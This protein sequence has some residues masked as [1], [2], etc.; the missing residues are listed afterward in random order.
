MAPCSGRPSKNRC[1]LLSARKQYFCVT[2][3][4]QGWTARRPIFLPP[5]PPAPWRLRVKL[6][7]S[8][9]LLGN[10]HFNLWTTVIHM[11]TKKND[12]YIHMKGLSTSCWQY[13]RIPIDESGISHYPILD[14]TQAQWYIYMPIIMVSM[15]SSVIQELDN[16]K[17]Q[18]ILAN[19]NLKTSSTPDDN[20]IEKVEMF[21]KDPSKT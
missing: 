8:L 20:L 3:F 12:C 11:A 13:N 4:F 15:W 5:H 6:V 14:L 10:I 7:R 19:D 1:W 21:Q 18:S 2:V 16:L 17:G 9:S